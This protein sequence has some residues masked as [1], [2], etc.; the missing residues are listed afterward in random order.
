MKLFKSFKEKSVIKIITLSIIAMLITVALIVVVSAMELNE[1]NNNLAKEELFVATT[2]LHSEMEK[3][4]TGEWTYDS[5]GFK[6]YRGGEEVSA[7]YQEDIDELKKITG[8]D[9]TIFLGPKDNCVRYITTIEGVQGKPAATE[10]V[11]SVLVKG[12]GYSSDSTK[13]GGQDYYVYYEPIK[14]VDESI[15][16]MVFTGRPRADVRMSIMSAIMKMVIIAIIAAIVTSIIGILLARKVSKCLTEVTES[17]EKMQKGNLSIVVDDKVMNRKDDIGILARAAKS[18]STSLS[19]IVGTIANKAVTVDDSSKSLSESAIRTNENVSS[20]TEAVNEIATGATHQAE[21]IQSGVEAITKASDNVKTLVDEADKAENVSVDMSQKADDM[22]QAFNKLS[23]AM[24]QTGNSL[25]EVSN[26][27]GEVETIVEKVKVT[28]ADIDSIA[29]QTNLLSL[30]ASIEAARAGEAG[31]GFAVVA[32]EIGKL[33][34]QTK[35]SAA[36]I[37]EVMEALVERTGEAIKTMEELMHM[38]NE[39]TEVTQETEKNA[40]SVI[41]SVADTK[42]ALI[43]MKSMCTEIDS[44]IN[45]VNEVMSSLSAISEENAASSEETSASMTEVSE[46][47]SGIMKMSEDM[48]VVSKELND[49]LSFFKKEC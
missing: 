41:S 28:M 16:G 25:S 39:Q 18:L 30:N 17:M 1:T 19:E 3:E 38:V 5:D 42:T 47:V 14:N 32:D 24:E 23:S 46:T 2:E 21:E 37:N 11:D 36:S 29:G 49:A 43:T 44:R 9:Y 10:V 40:D 22:K 13:V 48:A 15:V 31:R 34:K 6:V 26:S 35:T 33:A 8:L 20:I 27:M 7:A 12:E 45:E 4:Y